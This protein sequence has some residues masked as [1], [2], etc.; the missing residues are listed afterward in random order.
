MQGL[1]F[2]AVDATWFG[3]LIVA[4]VLLNMAMLACYYYNAPAGYNNAIILLDAAFI[5]FY[6]VEVL[7]K[8][9]CG[10]LR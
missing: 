2:D 8:L 3:Q 1:C 10:P 5:A 7:M 4:V 9:L 6:T